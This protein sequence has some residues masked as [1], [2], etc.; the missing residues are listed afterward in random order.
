MKDQYQR[1]AQVA[2]ALATYME[3][4]PTDSAHDALRDTAN[5]FLPHRLAEI[6]GACYEERGLNAPDDEDV[7]LFWSVML[8]PIKIH[9][10]HA[11][12]Q[13][14]IFI[15]EQAMLWASRAAATEPSRMAQAAIPD[16]SSTTLQE[17]ANGLGNEP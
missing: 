16:E 10:D 7:G 15:E 3:S 17:A 1:H 8:N 11:M 5:I 12:A 4:L 14:D 9:M 13:I 2:Y 6:L